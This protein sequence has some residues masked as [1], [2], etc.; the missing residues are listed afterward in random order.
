MLLCTALRKLQQPAIQPSDH[1]PALHLTAHPMRP[2]PSYL[3]GVATRKGLGVGVH[4]GVL[5][6]EDLAENLV[7]LLQIQSVPEKRWPN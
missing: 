2:Q 4:V 6:R 5:E 3:V 1:P 7:A